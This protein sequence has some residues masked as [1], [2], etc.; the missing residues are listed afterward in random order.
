MAD[1]NREETLRK[2]EAFN[3]RAAE[4]A[5]S[6]P[7]PV[8]PPVTPETSGLDLL[9]A[10]NEALSTEQRIA[11]QAMQT[12]TDAM[13]QDK[14]RE[15]AE[16]RRQQEEGKAIDKVQEAGRQTASGALD[17]AQPPIR[18]LESIPTPAGI[19]TILAIIAVFLLAVVPV[20]A[21][22]NTRLK[23]IWLTISG[24]TTLKPT[25]NLPGLTNTNPTSAQTSNT[26]TSV[27]QQVPI[28]LTNV[29][30]LTG[31]DLTGLEGA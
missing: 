31:I 14:Q 28:D 7:S 30:D 1:S 6:A 29:P 3:Q 16:R 27:A 11:K 21:A 23:L 19:G 20:D 12:S 18:W 25:G 22:G 13:E 17:A 4:L 8:M 5:K 26:N 9:A 2:I 10:P 24:K 15:A